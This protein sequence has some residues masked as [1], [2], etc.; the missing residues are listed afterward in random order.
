MRN[1]IVI[2]L[3]VLASL[4]SIQAFASTN[5]STPEDFKN[6][7]TLTAGESKTI[8]LSTEAT[9]FKFEVPKGKKVYTINT[10]GDINAILISHY[11][12]PPS[13]GTAQPGD[14]NIKYLTDTNCTVTNPKAGMY[15]GVVNTGSPTVGDKVSLSLSLG[16]KVGYFSSGMSVASAECGTVD[17]AE[18]VTT[19]SNA[20]EMSITGTP[21]NL[22]PLNSNNY[23]CYKIP[24]KKGGKSL[25]ISLN[26]GTGFSD[27]FVGAINQAPGISDNKSSTL[28]ELYVNFD[29]NKLSC[30]VPQTK[31]GFYYMAYQKSGSVKYMGGESVIIEPQNE[32]NFSSK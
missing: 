2:L 20:R 9:C 32:T 19:Y 6:A 11:G 21:Q 4:S 8:S 16:G 10:G 30:V 24:V 26:P 22:G 23:Y 31:D 12:K 7:V 5:C 15:Y 29:G 28:C 27:L 1:K 18:D 3:G 13:F 17:K 25:N 14:C